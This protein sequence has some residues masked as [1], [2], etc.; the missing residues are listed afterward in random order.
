MGQDAALRLVSDGRLNLSKRLC[1]RF[2]LLIKRGRPVSDVVVHVRLNL[3]HKKHITQ[4]SVKQSLSKANCAEG[5]V[6]GST[7]FRMDYLNGSKVPR[8]Q[9]TSPTYRQDTQYPF[10]QERRY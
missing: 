1:K 7:N 6:A 8:N 2:M 4:Q 5:V 10:L 3:M 9:R